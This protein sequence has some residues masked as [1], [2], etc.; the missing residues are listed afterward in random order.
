MSKKLISFLQHLAPGIFLAS[1]FAIV[2]CAQQQTPQS[3]QR[4]KPSTSTKHGSISNDLPPNLN[5]KAEYLFFLH[6]KIVEDQGI[7]PTNPKHGVYEYEKI[8]TTF[9]EKGFVV[10]SEARP[11]DTDVNEY[12]AKLVKQIT[13][14]LNAGIPPQQITVLGAS[15]GAV[16]AMVTSTS[17]KNRNVNFVL[18]SNCN[19]WVDKNFKID[20]HGNLLSIYD[21][22]DEFG[23]SCK[24]FFDK[25]TGLNKN[26]EIELTIGTGHGILFKPLK[27]WV[28]PVT[29]WAR[30][31]KK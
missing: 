1:W 29:E 11:K 23:Q 21:I 27:E 24:P 20:L 28:G 10:I 2:S 26:R 15:K 16:I 9:K 19:A 8:L 14:L 22:N 12:S 4:E 13:T 25:A 18:M 6:G 17:L 7:R 31:G 3:G 30:Q 5:I